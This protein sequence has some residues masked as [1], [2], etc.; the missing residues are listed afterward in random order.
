VGNTLFNYSDNQTRLIPSVGLH[1]TFYPIVAGVALRPNLFARVNWWDYET[2]GTWDCE[3]G[4]AVDIPVT[5]LW[6]WT[7]KGGYRIWNIKLKRDH[8]TVDMTRRGFFIETS[9]LF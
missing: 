1:G 9:V 3:L 4:T 8:D 5:E 6:T 7:V 2:V